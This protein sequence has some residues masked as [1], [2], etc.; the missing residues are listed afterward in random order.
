MI[1][2]HTIEELTKDNLMRNRKT[3]TIQREINNKLIKLITITNMLMRIKRNDER[4]KE[5]EIE[6]KKIQVRDQQVN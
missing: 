2:D 5:K 3:K 4:K 6:K 1:R